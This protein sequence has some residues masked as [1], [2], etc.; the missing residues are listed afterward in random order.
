MI[1]VQISIEVNRNS[2][3]RI[4]EQIG[5][6]ILKCQ[7][8]SYIT[9]A[10]ANGPSESKVI[11]IGN[12]F[13]LYYH[14]LQTRLFDT[15]CLH[16]KKA[17][18][19]LIQRI[20]EINPDI[21]HLHHI[22]GYFLNME[23]LFDFL[24]KE[25]Y[26]VVW[27]FHDCW[28]FTGHC[29]YFESISCEKWKTQCHSCELKK[30]YPASYFA[31]RSAENFHIKKKLFTSIEN[32][33]IVPVSDWLAN[34]V[35][36]SFLKNI[37]VEVIHNGIDLSIFKYQENC[38]APDKIKDIKKNILLGVASLWEERKGLLDFIKLNEIIDREKYIIVLIG[39][40]KSQIRKL[41]AS[42]VGIEKT[43]DV[44]ELAAYYN[45]SM[46]FINPTS[47][48]TFPTTNLEAIACGTPV[49]TY[50]VGGGIEV[51]KDKTGYIVEKHKIEEIY[52]KVEEVCSNTKSYYRENC[53]LLAEKKFENSTQ[54]SKYIDLYAK[55]IL[56][57]HKNAT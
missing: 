55:L 25:S 35:K 13:D 10:R 44:S 45:S 12:S 18:L 22:H 1:I 48:D 5:H 27:T 41:P 17:T 34:Y 32:M 50:N 31:D 36:K 4:A 57:K 28:A 20:K 29:A 2:V 7:G 21:I 39:L 11:K 6:E 46:A 53:L 24:K 56:K 38:T 54:Y 42:I 26:P 43:D 30:S 49:I 33:T 52:K 40:S 51:I 37:P 14:G 8:E 3:G 19:K 23:I 47:D 16:S 9:Y 15:H